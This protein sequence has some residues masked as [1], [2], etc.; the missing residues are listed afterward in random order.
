[1]R[2][3]IYCAL[4]VSMFTLSKPS[5]AEPNMEFM[6]H[7]GPSLFQTG[8][9]QKLGTPTFNTNIEFNYY[10]ND[11]HGLGAS[12]GNEFDFEGDGP[13]SAFMDDNSIHTFDLHYAYKKRIPDTKWRFTFTPGLGWQTLYDAATDYYWGVTYQRS[14]ASSWVFNYKL[15][16]DYLVKEWSEDQYLFLGAGISQIWTLNGDYK[17]QDLTG[18]R[19]SLLFRIGVAF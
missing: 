14:L 18:S 2:F 11:N 19:T 7:L 5:K 8:N 17:G 1:M 13:L 15:M 4:F 3:L 6:F 10:L 9:I 16:L 12:W